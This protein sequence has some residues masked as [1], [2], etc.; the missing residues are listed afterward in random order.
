MNP[1]I[2]GLAP[3]IGDGFIGGSVDNKNELVREYRIEQGQFFD[4]G[5]Q[6]AE[7]DHLPAIEPDEKVAILLSRYTISSGELLA[8]VFKGKE[9]TR[10]IGEA[11]AGYTTGNGWEQVTDELIMNISE[12]VFVDRNKVRYDTKVGVDETIEFQHLVEMEEDRQIT[13]AMAWLNEE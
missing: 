2:A 7:M 8:V 4:T 5:N 13:R 3:L 12:G 9:N 11:T 1:M 10:F 6:V